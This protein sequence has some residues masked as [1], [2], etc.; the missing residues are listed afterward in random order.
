MDDGTP[1]NNGTLR[2][3]S[4]IFSP[5]AGGG[6]PA[7]PNGVT[8]NVL[9]RRT[10]RM[11]A[12]TSAA[13]NTSSAARSNTFLGNQDVDQEQLKTITNL[14]IAGRHGQAAYLAFEGSTMVD[15]RSTSEENCAKI[16]E[17]ITGV[18]DSIRR[19]VGAAAIA[20][21][22]I[23]EAVDSIMSIMRANGS[24]VVQDILIAVPPVRTYTS[25]QDL[26]LT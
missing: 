9:N 19:T 22:T 16:I 14:Q 1:R 4:D 11:S 23:H 26:E 25:V 17:V 3:T 20:P 21:E 8:D 2:N 10:S 6:N 13:R 24:A 5:Y 7:A 12:A 18:S 15:I